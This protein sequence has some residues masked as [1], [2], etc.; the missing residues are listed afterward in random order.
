VSVIPG[1]RAGHFRMPSSRPSLPMAKAGKGDAVTAAHLRSEL[2]AARRKLM[3]HWSRFAT[4][5]H[6][7]GMSGGS[8]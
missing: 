4:G 1:R 5:N 8:A 3:E 2:F 7:S 6:G